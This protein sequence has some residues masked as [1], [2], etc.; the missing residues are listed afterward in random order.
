MINLDTNTAIA[1]IAEGSPIRHELRAFVSDK[2]MVM[3]QTAFDEF[4][5]IAR[6]SGGDS[7]KARMARFILRVMVVSDN[8]SLAAQSLRPTRSLDV[9]DIIILGT[10]DQMGIVTMTADK[11]AIRAASSQGVNFNVYLHLSYSLTGS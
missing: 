6:Y 2:Q 8:L 9:N 7:E 4:V 5:N 3:A 11:K 1:F 10:G